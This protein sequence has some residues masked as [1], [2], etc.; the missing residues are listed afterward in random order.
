VVGKALVHE[1]NQNQVLREKEKVR[2]KGREERGVGREN[3]FKYSQYYRSIDTKVL[4]SEDDCILW[5]GSPCLHEVDG[6]P[7]AQGGVASEHHT[8]RLVDRSQLTV[9]VGEVLQATTFDKLTT[10][11][12]HY[13]MIR[14]WVESS[15]IHY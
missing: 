15:L 6:I 1:D 8:W 14:R 2:E 7:A 3:L 11:S 10:I 4:T 12:R 9:N 13:V 5:R